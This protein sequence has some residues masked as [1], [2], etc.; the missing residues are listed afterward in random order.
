MRGSARADSDID[1]LVLVRDDR[2]YADLMRRTS[3]A[4]ADLSLQNDIVISRMF[5]SR[6]RYEREQSPFF[7]YV[8]REGVA[9]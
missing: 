9:V 2:D 4:V 7:L 1:V 3:A 5:L 8:R 6:D